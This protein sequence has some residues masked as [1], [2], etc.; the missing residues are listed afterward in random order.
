M[1]TVW[2]IKHQVNHFL[3]IDKAQVKK[4]FSLPRAASLLPKWNARW[5]LG[6]CCSCSHQKVKYTEPA[7]RA[8]FRT[9][10]RKNR[11][12]KTAEWAINTYKYMKICSSLCSCFALSAKV[13]K[14][15]QLHFKR[16]SQY[17]REQ[18]TWSQGIASSQQVKSVLTVKVNLVHPVPV[19]RGTLSL[20]CRVHMCMRV[21]VCIHVH[22]YVYLCVTFKIL[23][24]YYF[25]KL[26][27]HRNI[28]AKLP[29]NAPVFLI[30]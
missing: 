29:V 11:E 27:H 7:T 26:S 3:A 8:K 15:P 4:E 28:T 10:A 19:H 13:K 24:W 9:N 17:I 14:A 2:Y 22:V 12:S 6:F 1:L 21:C 20:E 23:Y 16:N 18:A 30:S 25:Q 5:L